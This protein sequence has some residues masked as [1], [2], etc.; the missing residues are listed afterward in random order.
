M[1][2]YGT[3]TGFGIYTIE[4]G[5]ADQLVDRGGALATAVAPANK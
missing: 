1:R 4:L 5:R 2:Q 3:Q